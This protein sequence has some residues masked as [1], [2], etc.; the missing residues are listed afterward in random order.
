[1]ALPW[2]GS[3][4]PSPFEEISPV[5]AALGRWCGCLCRAC[6]GA[7]LPLGRHLS[8]TPCSAPVRC[9]ETGGCSEPV[10]VIL[11]SAWEIWIVPTVSV[12]PFAERRGVSAG[13]DSCRIGL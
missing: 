8:C 12:G 6:P 11:P 13:T 5:A 10:S 7:P 3:S 9:Q 2:L 1:M 4:G